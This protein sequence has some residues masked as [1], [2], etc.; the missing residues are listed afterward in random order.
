MHIYTYI[1]I[2]I[3]TYIYIVHDLTKS[4]M[5][6]VLLL[7]T[8]DPVQSIAAAVPLSMTER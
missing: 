7:A 1:Y 4:M 8:S 2:Y 6:T 5:A 3:Y